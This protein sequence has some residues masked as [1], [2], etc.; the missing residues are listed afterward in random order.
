MFV[1]IQRYDVSWLIVSTFAMLL[2]YAVVSHS[3]L[4]ALPYG[5]HDPWKH[6][7]TAREQQFNIVFNIYPLYHILVAQVSSVTGVSERAVVSRLTLLIGTIGT[8][9]IMMV[10]MKTKARTS[11][12]QTAT[13]VLLPALFLGFLARPF[14]LA[15]PFVLV[16]YWLSLQFT[17]AR[18]V[19]AVLILLALVFLHPLVAILT[20][21]VVLI[22]NAVGY[23]L[24]RPLP[25]QAE[26]YRSGLSVESFRPS[27]TVYAPF[28]IGLVLSYIFLIGTAFSDRLL[29][30]IVGQFIEV[31][32][33][34]GGGPAGVGLIT[35]AFSSWAKFGEF[36]LRSSFIFSLALASTV[37]LAVQIRRRYITSDAVVAIASG[38][39]VAALFALIVIV[40]AGVGAT[41]IFLLAP[42][43]FA[44]LVPYAFDFSNP[45]KNVSS[46][47]T[48]QRV[49]LVGLAIL[50]LSTGLLTAF[51]WPGIGGI[52]YS[53]TE[54][55][56]QGVDWSVNHA[57]SNIIGTQMTHWIIVGLYG[58]DKSNEFTR[59]NANGMLVTKNRPESYSWEV[60]GRSANELYVIDGAERARAQQYALESSQDPTRCMTVFQFT[61]SQLY[62]NGDTSMFVTAGPVDCRVV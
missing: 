59:P 52:D 13:I 12:Q 2:M 54:P 50:I 28:A 42:L 26:A 39:G 58:P 46:I 18:R 29:I 51:T 20:V 11:A 16:G 55:Q 38:L 61:H 22:G 4:W 6:I 9:F 35:E 53:A 49:R 31:G 14:S 36:V 33:D 19:V 40:P 41:R 60:R 3:F 27:V 44:P 1:A 24:R 48:P 23:I 8:L 62:D 34:S 10:T 7:A 25:S 47:I 21:G 32:T 37:A 56:V 17:P 30:A 45:C 57:E 5:F 15:Y 43:F